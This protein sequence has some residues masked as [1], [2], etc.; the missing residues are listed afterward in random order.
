[1][2]IPPQAKL[3]FKGQIFDVYQWEQKM[4]DGSTEVFEAIKRPGTVQVIPVKGDKILLAYEEQPGRGRRLSFFGGRMEQDEAPLATAMRELLEETGMESTSWDLHKEY[5]SGGKI[6]WPF[7][8]YIARDIKKVAEPKLDIGEKIDIREYTFD[9]F[10]EVVS[11]EEY[12]DQ[13]IGGEIYR[14]KQDKEK[15]AEFKNRL[16]ILK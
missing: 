12:V 16:F 6:D 3:A 15:L 7:F 11:S 10:V 4:Y 8:V 5:K 1:M 2:I 14:L 9:E 13:Q